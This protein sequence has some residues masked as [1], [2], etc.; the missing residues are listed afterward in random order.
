MTKWNNGKW[1]SW[2]NLGFNKED[3]EGLENGRRSVGDR[4]KYGWPV[5]K[6]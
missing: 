5:I 2:I 3:F 6:A 1:I 4:L